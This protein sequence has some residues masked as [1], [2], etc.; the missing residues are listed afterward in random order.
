MATQEMGAGED[1]PPTRPEGRMEGL[2]QASARVP[3][4][5][6]VAVVW[7]VIFLILAFLFNAADFDTQF[8]RERADFVVKGLTYTILIAS[9]S[10]VLAIL[11]A[12]VG[13]LGRLSHNPIAYGVSGFYTSF[14][15]GTPLIVQ[16]F[17]ITFALPVVVGN[18]GLPESVE[19]ILTLDPFVAGIVALG[20]NYGAY[21]TEIFRAGIQ[22]VS[23]GQSEAADALGMTY[24]QKMKRVVLPQAFRV[25]IPPTGNEFIAMMKDTAL[26][27]F[28]GVSAEQAEIFRRAQLAAAADFKPIEAYLLAAGM[29]WFLTAVFTFFQSRL[30]RR[31]SKGYVRGAAAPAPK[32]TAITSL[33]GQGGQGGDL[34]MVVE[35]DDQPIGPEVKG[36]GH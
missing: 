30:E 16:L 28:I 6:K 25:I 9:A 18:L 15:R 27:S 14:F 21:M 10:I 7:V 32:K 23:H 34:P 4:K 31:I 24:P 19:S 1:R 11:L 20:L 35:V 26:V 13:A 22:S 17:I 2:A 8:M 5:A 12:L 33:S 29:Y 3:F 36:Q